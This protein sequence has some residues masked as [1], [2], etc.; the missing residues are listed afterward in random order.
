MLLIYSNSQSWGS[1]SEAERAALAQGHQDLT[2]EL[3]GT[4]GSSA[5]RGCSVRSRPGR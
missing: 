5:V 2:A 1:L 4:G 3:R